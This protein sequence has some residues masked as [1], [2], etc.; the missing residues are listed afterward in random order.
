M[1]AGRSATG[2]SKM[3]V[4]SADLTESEE[5]RYRKCRGSKKNHLVRKEVTEHTHEPS[6]SEPTDGRK[7]LIAP[8][9]LRQRRM[10]NQSK[11]DRGNRRSEKSTGRTLDHLG[12]EHQRKTRPERE[13]P[14]ADED[15]G[16]AECDH[17]PLRSDPVQKFSAGDL[18]QYS[19]DAAGR[20]DE[21]N[22]SLRPMPAGEIDGDERPES[23]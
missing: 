1:V 2:T 16:N 6:R 20:Q 23:A 9:S 4:T 19:G 3:N 11:A 10:S 22:L 12:S 18:A 13:D 5:G 8:E 17:E 7:A 15:H 14:R 21:P